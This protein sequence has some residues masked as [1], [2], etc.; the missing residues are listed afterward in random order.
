MRVILASRNEKKIAEIHRL[1]PELRDRIAGLDSLPQ[2][3]E[4][5]ED[6]ESFAEN[7]S[8][9]AT[10][11]ATA[12]H[13]WAI[14]EDSGLCVDALRGE[15]G[16]YSARYAGRHGDDA[17][18]NAKLIAQMQQVAD[19][20]RDAHYHSAIALA[21]PSG[22]IVVLSEGQC[23]G[24]IVAD[25]RGA[26]GF[27]YDPHFLVREYHR[28]FGELSPVVKAAISHRARA[29]RTFV[30][31]MRRVLAAANGSTLD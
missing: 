31:A 16:I 7:A 10:T 19:G 2:L 4:I 27:G 26:N 12:G 9:K 5:V 14:G 18:N 17:A 30:P 3:G 11:A 6:G 25:A 22:K 20:R 23:H 15:P 13:C 29:M 24:H 21:D 8:I 28:T 1:L